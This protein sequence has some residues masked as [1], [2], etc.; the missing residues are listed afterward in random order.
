MWNM[1]GEGFLVQN[2]C[3]PSHSC[4]SIAWVRTL[5]DQNIQAFEGYCPHF[6][7]VESKY[8]DFC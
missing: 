7:L 5:L 6:Y 1:L 3:I 4:A 2:L 8:P